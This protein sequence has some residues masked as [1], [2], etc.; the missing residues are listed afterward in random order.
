MASPLEGGRIA[1][2]KIARHQHLQSA[3]FPPGG[4]FDTLDRPFLD[5][6]K[7]LGGITLLENIVILPIVG[8]R[9]FTEHLLA[10]CSRQDAQERDV[11]KSPREVGK[12]STT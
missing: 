9:H 2:E 8:L 4:R 6:V 12:D 10:V 7:I 11:R 3:L 1:T 5:N